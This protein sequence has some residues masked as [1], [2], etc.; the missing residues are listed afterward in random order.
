M[1][2]P[3]LSRATGAARGLLVLFGLAALPA[4]AQEITASE[5][6][7]ALLSAPAREA[8]DAPQPS[9][10]F[11]REINRRGNPRAGEPDQGRGDTWDRVTPPD[12]LSAHGVNGATSPPPTQDFDGNAFLGGSPPDMAASV[13]PDHVVQ[14][15]NATRVGIWD[16]DGTSVTTFLFGNLWD[17][18][19]PCR[20]NAGDPIVLYDEFADRWLLTQ[21]GS[22]PNRICA[23]VSTTADPGGTYHLYQFNVPQFPDYFKFGVWPDAYYM[24]ANEG[25]YTAYAFD[26][27]AMLT[28]A[29]ATFQRVTGQNN[30]LL[31]ADA[32]GALPPDGAPGLFYTMKDTAQHGVATDRLEVYRYQVDFATPANS[33]FALLQSIP[34]TP[35]AYT[36]CGFFNFNCVRQLGTA[37]R[38][39]TISEWPM[40]RL[41]YR[42]FEDYE[43]L[44]GNFTV[45][46][47]QGNVG[48]AVRWFEL[49]DAG[50]GW[51]LHQEG[52]FD[53]PDGH[54]RWNGSIAIDADGNMALGYSVSSNTIAP[55]IAYTSRCAGDPPGTMRAEATIFEGTG[56]NTSN[57]RWGDYSSMSNDPSANGVF[58]FTSQ[59]YATGSTQ[60]RT[61]LAE[62]A[63]G[64]PSQLGDEIFIDGFDAFIDLIFSNGFELPPPP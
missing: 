26:R 23:A 56:A 22:G 16:K 5:P 11:D 4:A 36:V 32:N 51:V 41:A 15:T 2:H 29:P 59:Y 9:P 21:F 49:R 28:G 31:P 64:C 19:Q 57:N 27:A 61:R 12:A 54:D 46:G 42:N 47:G 58:W 38:V 30:L 14:M 34:V 44:V 25:S 24:S 53:P 48:A 17:V 6:F 60:W 55:R 43:A 13:G 40:F 45:G 63:I 35:F 33:S 10:M 52:T 39:D 62:L 1:I 8:A 18:G 37:Q 3:H 7:P 50:A 20:S